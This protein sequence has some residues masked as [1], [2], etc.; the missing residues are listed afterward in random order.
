MSR[1]TPMLGLGLAALLALAASIARASPVPDLLCQEAKSVQVDPRTLAVQ[2]RAA[3]IVYRFKAGSLYITGPDRVESLYAKVVELEPM[4]YN[5]GRKQIQ[6]EL[7]GPHFRAATLVHMDGDEVG[8]S[9][10]FCQR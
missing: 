4:R 5:A 6:F 1:A 3:R 10:V 8:V 7:R 2:E 9:R